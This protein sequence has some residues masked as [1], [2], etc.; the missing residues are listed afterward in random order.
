MNNEQLRFEVKTGNILSL[1]AQRQLIRLGDIELFKSYIK[2]HFLDFKAEP[3]LLNPTSLEMLSAYIDNGN[4]LSGTAQKLLLKNKNIAAFKLY[5]ARKRLKR[6]L[7]PRLISPRH[8][9]QVEAYLANGNHLDKDTEVLLLA[10]QNLE[11]LAKCLQSYTL[12][13]DFQ[14]QLL[15]PQYLAQFKVF[16]QHRYFSSSVEQ[17]LLKPENFELFLLYNNHFSLKKKNQIKMLLLNR[18]EM[19]KAFC[20]HW[21]ISYYAKIKAKEYASKL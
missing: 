1:E 3:E 6:E 21:H 4:W 19:I 7:L 17:E 15:L 16:I 5:T 8:L 18:K 10:P 9:L 14:R 11:V 20:K 12:S 2:N 13:K